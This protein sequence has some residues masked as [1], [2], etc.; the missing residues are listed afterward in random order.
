MVVVAAARKS[1]TGSAKLKD[2]IVDGRS[3]S[4]DL[5][6]QT[7]IITGT[8]TASTWTVKCTYWENSMRESNYVDPVYHELFH[9]AATGAYWLS[10]R[11]VEAISNDAGFAMRFAEFY[12]VGATLL[13]QCNGNDENFFYTC[14]VR[15]VVSL[16][17]NVEI[18]TSIAGKDGSSP[19]KAWTIK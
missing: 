1:A 3:G 9:T 15:P 2:Q 7:S 18:D 11:C 12:R 14:C 5:S 16:E 4:L 6:E 19:D 13:F 10:S 17:S 8:G